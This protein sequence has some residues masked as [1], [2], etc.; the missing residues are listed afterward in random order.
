MMFTVCK[1]YLHLIHICSIFRPPKKENEE[2]LRIVSAVLFNF[3]KV[4]FFFSVCITELNH[5]MEHTKK[6]IF[7]QHKE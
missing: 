4:F 7:G 3:L 1:K 5:S 2:E 6:V